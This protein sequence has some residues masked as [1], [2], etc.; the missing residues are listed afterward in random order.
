MKKN[1]SESNPVGLRLPEPLKAKLQQAASDSGL[2]MNSAIV[3]RLAA[4]FHSPLHAYSDADL[5]AEL[6]RRYGRG[7]IYIRV[8]PPF[9]GDRD[10]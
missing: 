3:Q 7:E 8:G 2:S 6:M 4:S 5:V 1:I 10:A 9:A